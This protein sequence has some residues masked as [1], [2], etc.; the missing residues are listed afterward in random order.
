MVEVLVDGNNDDPAKFINIKEEAIYHPVVRP[1]SI[2]DSATTLTLNSS[3]ATMS[4]IGG[5]YYKVTAGGVVSDSFDDETLTAKFELDDESFSH[6]A[7]HSFTVIDLDLDGDIN[8]DGT[9]DD[10]DDAGEAD[11][12]DATEEE[13]VLGLLV[14][15]NN[16]THLSGGKT[17]VDYAD[18][19]INGEDD[20]QDMRKLKV[21]FGDVSLGGELVLSCSGNDKIRIFDENDIAVIGPNK[22][23][24]SFIISSGN[25]AL[26]TGL[27]YHIEALE[28]GHELNVELAYI[29]SGC[30][31]KVC[32][33]KVKISTLSFGVQGAVYIASLHRAFAVN[34]PDET[35]DKAATDQFIV[36]VGE[37]SAEHPAYVVIEMPDSFD[38]GVTDVAMSL[39]EEGTLALWDAT[40]FNVGKAISLKNNIKND[41]DFI[42]RYNW[43]KSLYDP[44]NQLSMDD[45]YSYYLISLG[46]PLSEAERYWVF[47]GIT[48]SG[49]HKMILSTD[50]TKAYGDL[51]CYVGPVKLTA[52]PGKIHMGF[53]PPN[54]AEGD[55]EDE[56]Y[57]ASVTEGKQNSIVNLELGSVDI[58][59]FLEFRLIDGDDFI[60]FDP[61]EITGMETDLV[62][63]GKDVSSVE[64]ATIALCIKGQYNP[65]A[66]VLEL[67]VMVLPQRNIEAGLYT[68]Y[69]ESSPETIIE[70]LPSWQD[71]IDVSN[72]VFTQAGVEFSI[73]P[74][75]GARQYPYD[76][77]EIKLQGG[78][79]YFSDDPANQREAD[80]AMSSE[81]FRALYSTYY[82]YGV[83]QP[84][85]TAP[86]FSLFECASHSDT[87]SVLFIN[88][89]NESYD[90]AGG[91]PYFRGGAGRPAVLYVKNL[92]TREQL[93][94]AVAHEVGHALGLSVA[95]ENSGDVHDLP[96]YSSAVLTDEPNGVSG[97][98]PDPSVGGTLHLDVSSKAIMAPG[99]P[100]GGL[101]PWIHGRWM[102]HEDW[103][104]A[105][106]TAWRLLSNE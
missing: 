95:D 19:V 40:E 84:I 33:D 39:V 94:L 58:A 31:E 16:N 79:P 35:H 23:T 62:L 12:E 42:D 37:L 25:S 106:N 48:T 36:G 3:K 46:I 14:A 13:K 96:P 99:S 55:S 28:G 73:H 45:Y 43:Y 102:C 27:E 10:S 104:A 7:S 6:S 97:L 81:E 17:E 64:E 100:V 83:E 70:E 22:E 18:D 29:P 50:G 65:D 72:D 9:I 41:Q 59:P 63:S 44:L 49:A 38:L 21:K 26:E 101:L 32:V 76:T 69:D 57:W 56:P 89:G 68:L 82:E 71:F 15:V 30:T 2:P 75:S 1:S 103:E 67:K 8:F 51:Q 78:S 66:F 77:R 88:E 90:P 80:G 92:V 24:H 11:P 4:S 20:K 86:K 47:D 93:L 85:Y 61:P 74:S 87:V 54:Y 98:K 60:T 5:G 52:D 34:V 91:P 105:N 53:D